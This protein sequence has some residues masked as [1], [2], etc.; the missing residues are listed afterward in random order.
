MAELKNPVVA[1]L[2]AV[3]E[4]NVARQVG[5]E[6]FFLD[7][8]GQTRVVGGG[9]ELERAIERVKARQAR[10]ESPEAQA[11]AR[12]LMESLEPRMLRHARYL[13]IG[14]RVVAALFQRRME[15]QLGLELLPPSPDYRKP[16]RPLLHTEIAFRVT[17]MLKLTMGGFDQRWHDRMYLLTMVPPWERCSFQE[18]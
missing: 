14:L 17:G 2:E 3:R 9:Q 18:S 6:V 12:A 13:A 10:M 1:T 7:D 11:S 4:A 15:D 16:A 8:Q 5:D